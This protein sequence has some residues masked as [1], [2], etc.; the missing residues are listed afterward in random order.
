MERVED[1]LGEK[2]PWFNRNCYRV[3]Q[4]LVCMFFEKFPEKI[5]IKQVVIQRSR[6]CWSQ[7]F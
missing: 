2:I 6:V 1:I 4:D 3:E 5:K 7:V